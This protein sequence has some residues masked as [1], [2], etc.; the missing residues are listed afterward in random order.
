MK[1][2]PSWSTLNVA[3]MAPYINENKYLGKLNMWTD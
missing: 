2:A 1:I 3:L